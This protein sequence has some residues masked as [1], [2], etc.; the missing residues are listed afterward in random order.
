MRDSLH[1]LRTQVDYQQ[2]DR[3]T[4]ARQHR[5]AR[6]THGH[7]TGGGRWISRRDAARLRAGFAELI[8]E[9]SAVAEQREPATT[10]G[11]R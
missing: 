10:G 2:Q 5:L 4:E 8:A 3:L 1:T 7:R 9:E 6:G 11:H